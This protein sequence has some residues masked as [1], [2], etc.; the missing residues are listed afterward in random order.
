M[1]KEKEYN[2]SIGLIHC[3]L[4]SHKMKASNPS[5]STTPWADAGAVYFL[6]TALCVQTAAAV[7]LITNPQLKYSYNLAKKSTLKIVPV[8]YHKKD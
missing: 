3:S 5:T 7:V 4:G 6:Y 8:K 1:W 2:R